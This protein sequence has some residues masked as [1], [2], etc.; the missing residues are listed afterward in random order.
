MADKTSLN[1]AFNTHFFEFLDDI[2]AI[3][4]ENDDITSSHT[5]F[6]TIRRANPTA[7]IKAWNSY[8][9][10]PYRAQIDVGDIEFF[11]QKDYSSDL[12]G[13]HNGNEI[14]K[15]IDKIRGPVQSMDEQNRQHCMTYIQNLSRVSDA[16]SKL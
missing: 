12:G 16:Y 15:I 14:V 8:V 2:I 11:F 3:Y 9:Y 4:P 10:A 7:L 13:V 6:S 5:A 1:R